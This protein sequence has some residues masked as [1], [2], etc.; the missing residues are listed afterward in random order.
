MMHKINKFLFPTLCLVSLSM[1]SCSD[2]D[3]PQMPADAI[4]L[5][6]MIGDSKTTIGGSDVYVNTS[7]NFTSDECGIA[8]LGKKG[9]FDRNPNLSQVAQEVAVTPGNFYQIALAGNIR[10]VAGERA[11]PVNTNYYN[12]YV[13][14]WIYNK[15][16]DISGVKISY[17]ECYPEIRQLPEW[18]SKVSAKLESDG[19]FY[20]T[21]YSF[22]KGCNIDKNVDAYYTNGYEDL[23]DKLEIEIN[24]NQI[25]MSYPAISDHDPYVRLLVRYDGAYTRVSLD[26]E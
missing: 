18:D 17:K 3:E 15:D 21:T 6:M 14:S 24:A 12:V 5:N 1:I 8:V 20:K 9:G 10:T 11:I 7:S 25:V 4:S 22:P 16:K 26:F 2:D 19:Y 13:D 23:T